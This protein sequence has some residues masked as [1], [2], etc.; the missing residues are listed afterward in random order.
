MTYVALYTLT[1]PALVLVG[2]GIAIVARLHGRRDGQPGRSRLQRGALR[3]HLGRQQQRQRVRRHHGDLGLLPDHAGT[4]DAARPARCRSCWSCCSPDRW[5]SRARCPVTAGTLPTHHP[6]SSGCWS[7]SSCSSPA[8]PTSRRSPSDRSRRPSHDTTPT[9][10]AAPV[11]AAHAP[12]TARPR[13]DAGRCS[14]R[15]P[16]SCRRPCAS[17]TRATC[18]A[19][20]VMFLV[21]LGSVATTVAAIADPSTFTI[22]IA[23]W[24]WLTVL[25]GNLAEAVAEGRGKAQAASLRAART[26]TVARLLAADGT[27]SEVPGDPAEGRRPRGRRGRARSSP[28]TAT[29]S[30][31]SPRST[32]RRSPASP[33]RSS[34]R[35]AATAAPS[36]AA[37]RVLSDRIVVRITAAAGRDLPRQDDRAGRGHLAPQDAQRD[38]P[39]DPAGQPDAGLP[40]RGRDARAD[41]VVRRRTAGP[42][43][44]G[45]PAGLPDP[46]HHRRPARRPSASPAWTGWCG[47]TC[48]P[49]RAARSRPPA[50]SAPC[51]STR[52]APSPTATGRPAGSSRPRASGEDELRDTARLS[53]LADQT[54]EG[55][56]IVDLALAQGADDRDLPARRDLRRVHRPDPDVRRR[57]GRR[58]PDPQGCRLGH[59]RAGSASSSP[60]SCTTVVEEISRAGGTPLVIGR[61]AAD[62]RR[63]GA[64]RD[65]PQGRRQGGHGRAVRR[66]ARDGHPH[67]DDHRRQRAHRPGDRG[68]GRGRRLPRRGHARGQDG[69]HPQGAGG[70]PARRDDRRRHQ[71]RPGARRG[72]RRASR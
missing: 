4:G 31:A 48:S 56:S 25:F 8:S 51:C 5:P 42:R 3:L 62:G 24:L 34:G 22:S 60:S 14:P 61:R 53:S 50:T 33:P 26:D 45:R 40:G 55:R 37:P 54:P 52:P 68:R 32:S 13:H 65:P 6:S 46:D 69:L 44:A 29:S 20:P 7:A 38:R 58:H 18:G 23:V 49:C 70:R 11:R 21:W 64:R 16:S 59:R 47:S 12:R 72:R 17:S 71:R 9:P 63:A 36:P 10:P 66:A 1:T 43:G 30:R 2:T 19:R 35:P 27:E 39:V 28:A 67:G 57:P 41:G 15:A